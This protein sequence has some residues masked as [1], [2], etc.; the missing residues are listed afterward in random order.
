MEVEQL[1]LNDFDLNTYEPPNYKTCFEDVDDEYGDGDGEC[2]DGDDEYG[3]DEYGGDEYG[4]GDEYGDGD[5][6]GDE[7]ASE[8]TNNI[9]IDLDEGDDIDMEEC[10]NVIYSYPFFS[11]DDIDYEYRVTISDE[12]LL[13]E[14]VKCDDNQVDFEECVEVFA[15]IY[16]GELVSS[17]ELIT[18]NIDLRDKRTVL[19]EGIIDY[20]FDDCNQDKEKLKKKIENN[21]VSVLFELYKEIVES[22]YE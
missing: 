20:N 8:S 14:Q 10:D 22:V 12:E 6:E 18:K 5:G 2:G 11:K 4:E 3:D 7:G 13:L 21:K 16:R 9:E 17:F 19:Q 1:D 15:E